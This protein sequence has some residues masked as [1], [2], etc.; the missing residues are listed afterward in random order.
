MNVGFAAPDPESGG[1]R[2]RVW[3]RGVGETRGCGAGAA[4]TAVVLFLW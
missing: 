2:L 1:L 4:A 3:E